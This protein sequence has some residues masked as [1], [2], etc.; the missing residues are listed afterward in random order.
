MALF[1][2]IHRSLFSDCVGWDLSDFLDRHIND[3]C[4]YKGAMASQT[5]EG[6]IGS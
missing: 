5:I 6:S 3:V 1:V 2:S 4:F